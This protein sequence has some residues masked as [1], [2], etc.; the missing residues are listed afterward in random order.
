MPRDQGRQWLLRHVNADEYAEAKRDAPWKVA[1][2]PREFVDKMLDRS[3]VSRSRS[4]VSG[5]WKVSQNRLAADKRA[6]SRVSTSAATS[7]REMAA[8]VA[9]YAEGSGTP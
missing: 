7:T 6:R 4:C 8:L 2:A 9:R 1:D 5:K 3:S